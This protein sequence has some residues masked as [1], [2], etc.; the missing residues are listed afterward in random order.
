MRIR[1]RTVTFDVYFPKQNFYA[2]LG[3]W[4]R[5]HDFISVTWRV[6]HLEAKVRILSHNE[7]PPD[8]NLQR[9]RS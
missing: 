1:T 2:N 5:T 9:S 7:Q 4:I 8:P 6:T 3:R